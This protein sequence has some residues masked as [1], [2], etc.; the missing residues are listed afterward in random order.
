MMRA[1]LWLAV[2]LLVGCKSMPPSAPMAPAA[3]HAVLAAR[4]Q[5]LGVAHGGCGGPHWGM[6]GRVALSNGR[7]GG[8]GRLVWSQGEGVVHLELSAPL[9]RQ[10]WTLDVDT[11]GAVL[12]GLTTEPVRGTDAA[13]LLRSA[14][15]WEV[16]I[17]ALGCWLRAVAADPAAFGV[18]QIEVDAESLPRRIAQGGWT[19]EYEDWK[20]EL[21]SG[22]P[23]PS[24]VTAS[25]GHDRVRLVVDRWVAQ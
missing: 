19:V 15:G 2:I 21:F 13:E 9:T 6:I 14:T 22:L 18:A 12:R 20:P 4:A 7:E 10:S 11:N 23:M 3:G 8:S 17:S 24:R 5:A 16:P 25:R 1:G